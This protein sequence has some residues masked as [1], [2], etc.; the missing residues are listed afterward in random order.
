MNA[1]TYDSNGIVLRKT[2]LG[3]A[4]LI[5][6]L[7][8]AD[9]SQLRLVAKGARK[10]NGRFSSYLELYNMVDLLC[11]KGKSLDIVKECRVTFISEKLHS[12]PFYNTAAA[13]ISELAERVTQPELRNEKLFALTDKALH[14]LPQLKEEQVPI[15]AG[16]YMLKAFAFSGFR[17]SLDRCIYCDSSREW[18]EADDIAKELAFS[19]IDGG[20]VCSN[21]KISA[22][23][24]FIPNILINWMQALLFCKLED[25]SGMDIDERTSFELLSICQ[26]WCIT[27]IGKP[28]KSLNFFMTVIL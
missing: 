7:L 21:C 12:D 26:Q 9:G 27:H 22:E 23:T 19:Y 24:V 14:I 25:I 15:L 3:E 11:V 18:K 13:C 17:P 1:P 6:T 28:L 16:A 10:P 2:K 5:I 20:V 4:D 8:S